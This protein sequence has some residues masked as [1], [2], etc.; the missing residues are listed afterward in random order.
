[1]IACAFDGKADYVVTGD[2]DLLELQEFKGIK[3]LTAKKF[4]EL[5]R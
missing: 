5:M 4:L 1:M 3:I 2:P